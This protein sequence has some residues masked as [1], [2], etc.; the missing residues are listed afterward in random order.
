MKQFHKTVTFRAVFMK[1]LFSFF[2]VN[3]NHIG[4]PHHVPPREGNA[5]WAM[6]QTKPKTSENNKYHMEA[7]PN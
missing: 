1:S 7:E 4:H 5:G 3:Q 2:T 6:G